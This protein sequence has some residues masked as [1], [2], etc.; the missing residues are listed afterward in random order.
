MF[1]LRCKYAVREG[2]WRVIEQE[3]EDLVTSEMVSVQ[4]EM[5]RISLK[6]TVKEL[7]HFLVDADPVEDWSMDKKKN[8]FVTK[9][10]WRE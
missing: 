6:D 2:H 7:D 5:D 8:R 1:W 10:K 3:P 4:S 9:D